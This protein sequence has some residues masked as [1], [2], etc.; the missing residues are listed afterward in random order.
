MKE[1]VS[2]LERLQADYREQFEQDK[3]A[4]EFDKLATDAMLDDVKAKIKKAGKGGGKDGVVET[5]EI[6]KLKADFMELT[7]KA[8]PEAVRRLFKTNETSIQSMTKLN[9]EN[10]RGLL[11]F[12]DELMG[13]LANWDR[14]DKADERAYFLEGWNGNCSYTDVKIGRGLTN[15][16]NI[17]IS[18]LGGIQP[19]KLKR[20]VSVKATIMTM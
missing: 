14:E 3:A 7:A 1:P 20:Y 9:N 4:A 5:G 18:L 16:K 15:A 10:P 12:R 2:L 19:D 8:E 6:A 11:V 13:L 17:C